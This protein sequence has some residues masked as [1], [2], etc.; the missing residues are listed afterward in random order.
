MKY[1]RHKMN[2]KKKKEKQNHTPFYS[3]PIR[4]WKKWWHGSLVPQ[5]IPFRCSIKL[6]WLLPF[7]FIK[8]CLKKNKKKTSKAA[9]LWSA[10][11]G[12]QQSKAS[13]ILG[14]CLISWLIHMV[15]ISSKSEV[16]DFSGGQKPLLGGLTTIEKSR[17]SGNLP[18]LVVNTYGLNFIKIG[19][20]WIFRGAEASLEGLH[21]TCDAHFR[22]RLSYSSQKSCVK[23]WF[24]LVEIGGT[25]I[26]RGG[27]GR[28]L[29]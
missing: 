12:V 13:E 4:H 23:I 17:K 20:I 7:I 25:C 19:G 1:D 21:L 29:L 27:G 15:Y 2:W 5:K 6:R 26:F 3:P 24:G 14:I 18:Y 8:V 16:F 28:R 22:T 9:R 11:G 10:G